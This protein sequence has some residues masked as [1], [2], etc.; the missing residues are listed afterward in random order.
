MVSEDSARRA[1][2]ITEWGLNKNI[3]GA[4]EYLSK[5]MK[6]TKK[7]ITRVV[8]QYLTKDYEMTVIEQNK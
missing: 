4:K 1:D 2:I 3:K 6:V 8:N 7:D 5:I